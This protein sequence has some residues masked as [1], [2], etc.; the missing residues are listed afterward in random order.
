MDPALR[1]MKVL[2]CEMILRLLVRGDNTSGLR[3]TGVQHICLVKDGSG[4]LV[5]EADTT[6][7]SAGGTVNFRVVLRQLRECRVFRIIALDCWICASSQFEAIPNPLGLVSSFS[8]ISCVHEP[9]SPL[10]S[11]AGAPGCR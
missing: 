3:A 4:K 8:L 6:M 5:G 11:R 9:L 2:R 7:L 1:L 10:I